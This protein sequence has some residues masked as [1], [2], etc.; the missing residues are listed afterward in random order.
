MEMVNRAVRF[1]PFA[2][3]TVKQFDDR[4]RRARINHSLSQHICTNR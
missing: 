4:L 2:I 3:A 1:R